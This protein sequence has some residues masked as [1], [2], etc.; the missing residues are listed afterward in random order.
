MAVMKWKHDLVLKAFVVLAMIASI[1]G[2]SGGSAGQ[3]SLGV[4]SQ[5]GVVY[6]IENLKTDFAKQKLTQKNEWSI[7][8]LTKTR[9]FQHPSPSC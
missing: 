1:V 3:Q 9:F 5:Q 2:C 7:T 4:S 6:S 8:I